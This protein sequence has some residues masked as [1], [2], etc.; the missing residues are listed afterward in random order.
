VLVGGA[1]AAIVRA[2]SGAPALVVTSKNAKT[3]IV[4]NINKP[5]GNPPKLL[6]L[7][8]KAY[9]INFASTKEARNTPGVA[10]ANSR[11]P[12]IREGDT[13]LKG[14]HANMGKFPGQV[15]AKMWG[16]RFE[17]WDEFR[18]TFWKFVAEDKILSKSFD[19][20]SIFRMRKG[21]APE[22]KNAV[23]KIGKQN[24]YH[25]HHND[26]LQKGGGV[27]DMSNITI[28]TPVYHSQF[29]VKKVKQKK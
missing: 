7:E 9:K 28:A 27:Y 11:L 4:F 2:R 22:V 12:T 18:K 21:L 16:M 26:P 1:S 10:I 3:S 17:N 24:S 6:A 5:L 29:H 8:N 19:K 15:A 25:L 23:Q 13:W 20:E 14:T